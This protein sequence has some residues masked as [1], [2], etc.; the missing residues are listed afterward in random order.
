MFKL[1]SLD[2]GHVLGL[3]VS[4]N[5]VAISGPEKSNS[6]IARPVSERITI[7]TGT[8][9]RHTFQIVNI[10][11]ESPASGEDETLAKHFLLLLPARFLNRCKS[12]CKASLLDWNA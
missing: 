7:E 9:Y 11:G 1:L 10:P 5:D 6:V 4:Q 8:L 12:F 2:F 3:K